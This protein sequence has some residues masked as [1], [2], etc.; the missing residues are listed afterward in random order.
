MAR[1]GRRSGSG[2]PA[3]SKNKTA[4][5]V[6]ALAQEYGEEAVKTL[7]ALI[8]HEEPS[9]KIAAAKELLDRAYGKA[10]QSQIHEGNPDNPIKQIVEHTFKSAI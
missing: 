8:S 10:P 7:A 1:G 4:I 2:R 5:E 3:G 6:R 9:V